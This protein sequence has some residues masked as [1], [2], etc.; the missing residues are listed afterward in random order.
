MLTATEPRPETAPRPA[1]SDLLTRACAAAYLG[2]TESTLATWACTNKVRVPFIRV[3]RNVRYRRA[4]LDAWL[5]ARTVNP[6]AVEG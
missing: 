2:T 1:E 3:G 4:D 6:V 5:S